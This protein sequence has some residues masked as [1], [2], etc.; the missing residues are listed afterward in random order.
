MGYFMT[1]RE[2]FLQGDVSEEVYT[3]AY[4]KAL[5]GLEN[6]N[7]DD[8][9]DLIED[10]MESI[11]IL[12]EA[13]QDS[14]TVEQLNDEYDFILQCLRKGAEQD[15]VACIRFLP[16]Y[17]SERIEYLHLTKKDDSDIADLF[18]ELMEAMSNSRS[19]KDPNPEKYQAQLSFFDASCS[20]NALLFYFAAMNT[21]DKEDQKRFLQCAKT[22][23]E[24]TMNRSP[25]D[26]L[27]YAFTLHRFLPGNDALQ[28]AYFQ[29][30]QALE[31]VLDEV[32]IGKSFSYKG[33]YYFYFGEAYHCGYGTPINR[34]K[35]V[36]YLKYGQAYGYDDA[37]ELLRKEYGLKATLIE[38]LQDAH[39]DRIPFEI[40]GEAIDRVI[41]DWSQGY[42]PAIQE[43]T[44]A[45][46]FFVAR[47]Q[48][49]VNQATDK[50]S[51]DKAISNLLESYD[52]A[53]AAAQKGAEQN[54]PYCVEVFAYLLNEKSCLLYREERCEEACEHFQKAIEASKKALTLIPKE[55]LINPIDLDRLS[56]LYGSCLM[57]H[58]AQLHEMHN[59]EKRV[60]DLLL[61]AQEAFERCSSLNTEEAFQFCLLL[62][63]LIEQDASLCSLY[64]STLKKVEVGI[65]ELDQ[66]IRRGILY[67]RLAE[68]YEYGWGTAV[69][70]NKEVHYLQLAKENG[71]VDAAEQLKK[72]EKRYPAVL[73]FLASLF[74]IFPL[75]TIS[76]PLSLFSI[77]AV[78]IWAMI[79]SIK[80][81]KKG[82]YVAA[83]VMSVLGVFLFSLGA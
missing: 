36:I 70:H 29:T 35:A 69:D 67:F 8:I 81:K 62:R 14:E 17:L 77:I 68:A 64:F 6:G 9:W 26:H 37:K 15:M 20:H 79:G 27:I 33:G 72:T 61:S 47:G 22:A 23:V 60:N 43:L 59:D 1:V 39:D 28:H 3:A 25:R 18:D 42:L 34:E 10:S 31:P 54:D 48:A 63:Q 19:L 16:I 5:D 12:K 24:H 55:D 45:K 58:A 30:L 38:L 49:S 76:R 44:E 56:A 74:C 75:I 80:A 78:F 13:A 50:T 32:Q 65:S 66:Q 40:Y 52:E 2:A 83:I 82:F 53:I 11:N 57:L 71:N 4:N 21:S 51:H 41:A 73:C 7:A 46:L